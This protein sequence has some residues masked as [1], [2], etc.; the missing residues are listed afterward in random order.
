MCIAVT[1]KRPLG[2]S[3]RVCVIRINSDYFPNST[4]QLVFLKDMECF[5]WGGNWIF[6]CYLN[7][8]QA[9]EFIKI[10][11]LL[12]RPKIPFQIMQLVINRKIRILWPLYTAVYKTYYLSW[13]NKFF[14]WISC[15]L[16]TAQALNNFHAWNWCTS[17]LAWYVWRFFTLLH[18]AWSEI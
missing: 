3:Y 8:C 14:P 17:P 15:L 18:Q 2:V 9:S 13:I 5:L 10:K 16:S 7:E 1:L 4:N 6:K 11:P 12:W